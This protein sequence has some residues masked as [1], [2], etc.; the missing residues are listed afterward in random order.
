MTRWRPGTRLTLIVLGSALALSLATGLALVHNDVRELQRTQRTLAEGLVRQVARAGHL[1]LLADNRAELNEIARSVLETDPILGSAEIRD[2]GDILAA[3]AERGTRQPPASVQWAAAFGRAVARLPGLEPIPPRRFRAQIP[4]AGEGS[5]LDPFGTPRPDIGEAALTLSE[6]E[7]Q[8]QIA[9]V[10]HR[11]AA[12]A[13]ILFAILAA[14]GYG[15]G[16][17]SAR[18]LSRLGQRVRDLAGQTPDAGDG[19]AD[20]ENQ[21]TAIGERLTQSEHQVREYSE[22]LRGRERELALARD[23]ARNAA[24]MRADLVAGMSH[25]LRAPLTAILGHTSLLERSGLNGEQREYVATVRKSAR[26]LLGIID[27]VLAWSGLESGRASLDEVGFN[28]IETVEDT[29]NLLAPLAFEKDLELVHLIYRDVPVHLRGDPLRF[30]QI[31][32][33][34]VS[35][36]IKFTDRGGV[37]VRLMLESED[38]E[39]CTLRV[40][41][42]DTGRGIDARDMDRL[43]DMYERLRSG[44]AEA[45]SGLGLAIS[46]RLLEMMGG[47]ITVDS[48]PGRGSD[49][50]FVLPLRKAPHRDQRWMPWTGLQGKRAWLADEDATARIA[51]AHHLGFW[52]MDVTELDGHAALPDKLAASPD[53]ARPDVVLVGL[54]AADLTGRERLSAAIAACREAGLPVL[55]LVTSIDRDVLSALEG[56]GANMALPKSSNRLRLYRSLCDLSGV[57]APDAAPSHERPLENVPALV[58]DN[59]EAARRYLAALLSG[60]GAGVA[61]A[62]DGNEAV[63]A[64]RKANF[65]LVI[66]D[67]EMPGL[68]GAGAIRRIRELAAAGR[69][70]VIV[71]MTADADPERRRAL[72]AAGAD[73]SLVKPFDESGLWRAV[74]PHMPQLAYVPEPSGGGGRAAHLASDPELSALLAQELPRQTEAVADALRAGDGERAAAEIHTLHGTAAFYGLEAIR[75]AAATVETRIQAGETPAE[76]DLGDVEA[77]VRDALAAL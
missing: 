46:K 73:E 11:A 63:A 54:R 13:V 43:F 2:A 3:R 8:R 29:L 77:A 25:E 1:A 48:E 33:N 44:A 58:A 67:S 52:G 30:Q 18:P 69:Q 6:P 28:L 41:V 16:W 5:L 59:S 47:D 45:G 24:R 53:T 21:L 34:L 60:L 55:A 51:L 35:N 19:F 12:V 26:N 65:P 9:G 76:V 61:Q 62:A 50:Q 42:A 20:I 57:P 23:H 72:L 4:P 37:T 7:L 70:P 40:S 10:V 14:G 75:A 66:V 22:A 74:Q 31:L 56:L 68:D 39:R 38:D 49:F 32:T 15:V 64:W 36:A 27:D 17:F 71:A